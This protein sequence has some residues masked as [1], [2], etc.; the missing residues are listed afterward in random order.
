VRVTVTVVAA[1]ADQRDER[2][3]RLQE[4]GVA[5][6]AAVVRDG[7]QLDGRV[8]PGGHQVGL[9]LALRVAG[10]QRAPTGGGDP[11][12]RRALVQLA[13]RVAVRAARRRAEHVDREVAEDHPVARR[14]IADRDPSCRRLRQ[15]LRRFRQ[16]RRQRAVPHHADVE[17]PQDLRGAA[18]VVA[19]AVGHHE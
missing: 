1:H 16:L 4:R 19:M 3:A 14:H 18:H 7:E 6:G 17:S 2:P 12:D 8:L 9:R 11:Q 15:Q 13:P 5:G 10:E